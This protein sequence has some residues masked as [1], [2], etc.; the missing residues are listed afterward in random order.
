M[1][2]Q[3]ILKILKIDLKYLSIQ[4]EYEYAH[5]C[6]DIKILSY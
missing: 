1:Y 2:Y 5:Y 4:N 6:T 3:L